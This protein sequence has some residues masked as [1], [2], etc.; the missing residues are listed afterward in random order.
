MKNILNLL[1]LTLLVAGCSDKEI[2]EPAP[3]L[4]AQK[5]V[6][7][8]N[9]NANTVALRKLVEADEKELTVKQWQAL[10]EGQGYTLELSDG[11]SVTLLTEI[12]TLEGG[13]QATVY[14][15]QVGV[16]ATTEDDVCWTLDNDWLYA[17]SEANGQKVSVGGNVIPVIGIDD[18][19]RWTVALGSQYTHIGRKAEG[20]H[21]SSIFRA[22]DV[23]DPDQVVIRFNDST[24]PI[25]LRTSQGGNGGDTPVMGSLRRP[26]SPEQPAW[27]V[28]IDTWNTADPQKIIDLIP[29]D[30]RPYVIFN[31][32]LSIN[33]DENTGRFLT[34]EYGYETA[35]SWLRTCAENRVWAMVQPAS[36]GFCHFPDAAFYADLEG[37]VF[38]EFYR[39]YPNFVGFNYCEQFWGF[40][41]QFSVTYPQRLV[42]WTHLMELS[43]RYGGYLTISFCGPYWGAS[44]NAIAMH[45]RDAR[46]AEVCKAYPENLIVCEKFTS[47]Y[48][49]FD[50]ESTT[51]G[52]WLSGMAGQYGMRY[53]ICGWEGAGEE[54]WKPRYGTAQHPTAAQAP[55]LLEHIMLTGQTV[56]DGPE[57]IWT[58]DFK[59]V[60]AVSAGDG[61]MTRAWERFPQFDNVN[62]D[63]YRKILDGTIRIPSRKEVIE[64]SKYVIIS[65]INSGADKDMYNA[66]WDLF[67]GLYLMDDDGE[68]YEQHNYY[69]KTG[70]YPTIP[71]VMQLAD[72]TANQFERKI[73]QS[74]FAAS[75][76]EE[77]KVQRFNRVF[78]SEYTGNLYAGRHE[79]GWVVY[80]GTP[81][82]ESA[83]IPFRYNTCDRMELAYA[84]LTASVVK[85]YADKVTFYLT[86]YDDKGSLKT[87]VIRIHGCTSK[88]SLGQQAR[89]NGT[90]TVAEEWADGTYTVTVKHNGPLDLEIRCNGTATDRETAYT[91]ASVV[92]PAQPQTYHGTHQIEAEYF[93]YKNINRSYNNAVN[94]GIRN[95]TAMGYID[96]G[97]NGAAAV[98]DRVNVPDEGNY[99]LRIRY[100]ATSA[101][102]NTVDLYVNGTKVG[103]PQFTQTAADPE[104]WGT[105]SIGAALKAGDN[106]IELRANG[107]TAACDLYL[108][109]ITIDN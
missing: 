72:E 95:Y 77:W 83:S 20:G 21:L 59:E 90:A 58:Q 78:P 50:I 55:V 17:G 86:N 84:S 65:D 37:S 66:P 10:T 85:E 79:N 44:L 102:V 51:L 73:N 38:E 92:T 49:F 46:F 22:V 29:D 93:D 9:A 26:I 23:S 88:P 109:H 101:T 4:P 3:M 57:L 104:V 106:T 91:A 99:A 25:A 18:E 68:L 28:H 76:G 43:H 12:G 100:R 7:V 107:T 94:D 14:S 64:R 34:V 63:I 75:W 82:S 54:Y 56:F 69:K 13:G 62:I 103:T 19:G 80:N 35:K 11:N 70:R 32:S 45:K 47:S 52:T 74:D 97:S 31:I 30:I 40:D 108:D 96:F 71:V 98:R 15:P 87:E 39:D 67:T 16:K 33:H 2:E 81:R 48:G 5:Q 41:D 27:I 89:A 6:A 1:L 36:G 8:D 42:H 61:Y 24:E 105:V 60:N 53:D